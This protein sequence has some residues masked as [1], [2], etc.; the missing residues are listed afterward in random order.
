MEVPPWTL[1]LPAVDITLQ[2]KVNKSDLTHLANTETKMLNIQIY[3]SNT[4]L[5]GWIKGPGLWQGGLGGSYTF[6]TI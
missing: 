5:Y 6:P 4:H 1:T 3:R 2:H